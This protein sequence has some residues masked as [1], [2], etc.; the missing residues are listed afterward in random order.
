MRYRDHKGG[1]AESLNTTRNIYSKHELIN[2]LNE[3]Y[4]AWGEGITDLKFER[5]RTD[6][7]LSWD[8]YY[9]LIKLQGQD[10]FSVAGMSDS[11]DFNCS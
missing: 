6:K 3:Q 7:K 5:I 1:L 9:V 8:A 11:N 4:S 10:D 2:H